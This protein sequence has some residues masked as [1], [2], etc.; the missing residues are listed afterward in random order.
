[1]YRFLWERG[2]RIEAQ[3]KIGPFD[4]ANEE[5]VVVMWYVFR[6]GDADAE[7]DG[8]AGSGF[9]S[10]RIFQDKFLFPKNIYNVRARVHTRA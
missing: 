1:M 4:A 8:G 7:V 5:S 6:V 2:K 10:V 3:A 9:E